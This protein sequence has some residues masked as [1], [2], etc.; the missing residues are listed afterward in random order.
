MATGICS[1]VCE[2][3]KTRPMPPWPNIASI[4]YSS[5]RSVCPT[6]FSGCVA[7]CLPCI[8]D[9]SD[10][11]YHL[12]PSTQPFIIHLNEGCPSR[13][14]GSCK[15]VCVRFFACGHTPHLFD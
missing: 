6:E 7:L 10:M 5:L 12:I 9:L 2:A 3:R 15:R 8:S 4:M 14:Q 13:Q 11:I 1:V